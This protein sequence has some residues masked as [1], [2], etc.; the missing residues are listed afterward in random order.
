MRMGPCT[1]SYAHTH[2][3]TRVVYR[4][5]AFTLVCPQVPCNECSVALAGLM[6]AQAPINIYRQ[7]SR[8]PSERG[9][10]SPQ[11]SEVNH[12]AAVP[13]LWDPGCV[14]LA[15]GGCPRPCGARGP[16]CAPSDIPAKVPRLVS[17]PR[18][19]LGASKGN[20]SMPLLQGQ[21]GR[22]AKAMSLSETWLLQQRQRLSRRDST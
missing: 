10:L 9:K 15:L 4:T 1:S 20:I 18:V 14:I 8:S 22:G 17:T 16:L 21:S 13:Y 7:H 2:R 6:E 11:A 3:H 5:L 12:A 19:L